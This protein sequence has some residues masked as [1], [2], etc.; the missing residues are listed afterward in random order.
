MKT[1]L[2]KILLSIVFLHVFSILSSQSKNS[3][4]QFAIYNV[5]EKR[6]Q[7]TIII[8]RGQVVRTAAT[9]TSFYRKTN[10]HPVWTNEWGMNAKAN[11]L[12]SA[13]GNA[14]ENGLR[15]EDYHV[16]E[17]QRLKSVF[18]K[19]LLKRIP[20]SQEDL[21]EAEI[22]FTDAFLL[23][24]S[25]LNYGKTDPETIDAYWKAER[26]D[27]NIELDNYLIHTLQHNTP[28]AKAFFNLEPLYREYAVF[29]KEL[30]VLRKLPAEA[31]FKKIDFGT[32]KKIEVN[33]TSK[34]IPQIK[35]RLN[36]TRFY[37]DTSNNLSEI[38]DSTLYKAIKLFQKQNGLEAD[39]VIGKGTMD[40]L[41]ISNADRIQTLL[42][43]MERM[44]WLPHEP[45]GRYIMVNIADFNMKLIDADSIVINSNAIVGKD[46]RATP[47]FSAKMTYL[48]FNPTW[49][50]PPTI[51]ANDVIPD[52]RKDI[53]YLQKKKMKLF[54]S[55]GNIVDPKTID[56]KKMSGKYF[57]YTVRQ[58]PGP[59]NSLGLLKFMFPNKHDVYMHDTPQKELFLKN[60]RAFSSGCIRIQQ[61]IELAEYLL[62]TIEGFDRD[63]IES[64]LKSGKTQQ[65]I[66]PEPIMVHIV[67]FTAAV[68]EN[69][70]VIFRKD[71]YDRDKALKAALFREYKN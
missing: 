64:I 10:Y 2:K 28:T 37:N 19:S 3:A 25:H 53:N 27:C 39:G 1:C 49:T 20:P 7:D 38:Y 65:V 6:F 32:I 36:A 43:N 29:K 58:E 47:V 15:I 14:D 11:E 70:K 35:N 40:A 48:V 62:R 26:N 4:L 44:R 21:L 54:D 66:L 42:L 24:S 8:I 23:Y 33:D 57:P 13:L 41:N 60:E 50:V 46:Y 16:F 17:L 61:H 71:I 55:K 31:D 63:S 18:E 22:L 56:W 59:Q 51:L 34:I 67:Y 69:G 9:T 45:E 30:S 52:T 12:L 68:N 5:V